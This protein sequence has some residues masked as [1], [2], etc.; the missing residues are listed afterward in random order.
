MKPVVESANPGKKF[1]W[2]FTLLVIFPLIL[3]ASV[4]MITTYVALQDVVKS[5]LL[6]RNTSVVGIAANSADKAINKYLDL[7][8][9]TANVLEKSM[10]RGEAIQLKLLDLEPY[11]TSFEGGVTLL[12]KNGLG[13]ASTQNGLERV[14]RNYAFR[15]Y[16]QDVI[17]YGRPVFSTLIT[18]IPSGQQAVVIA[19][20]VHADAQLEGVLIGVFFLEDHL[21]SRDLEVLQQD[22]QSSAYLIDTA[23]NILYHSDPQKIGQNLHNNPKITNLVNQSSAKSVLYSDAATSSNQVISFAPLHAS[24]WGIVIEEPWEPL[25]APAI[26]YL[27]AVIGFLLLGMIASGAILV[28]NLNRSVAPLVNLMNKAQEISY[29]NDFVPLKLE[30]SSEIRLLINSFNQVVRSLKD[31]QI[32]L[33]RYARQILR[34]QEQERQRISRD[35]HDE[36]VQDLVGL[37]QRLELCRTTLVKD[38]NS[39]RQRLDELQALTARTIDEVRRMSNN[40]RPLILEDLGLI[41]AVRAL[42]K[43]L[44]N[45]IPHMQVNLVISGREKRLPAEIEL[46]TFRVIQESLNNIRKH[47]RSATQVNIQ[48]N[49]LSDELQAI[50]QDN[51]PGFDSLVNQDLIQQ[52]HLGLAGM[53]ERARL[54]GG[55]L[56]IFA[57]PGKFTKVILVIPVQGIFENS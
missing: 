23:G 30:G 52:G 34:S 49:Y 37:S 26:P 2:K 45:D 5:I 20:P 28:I 13:M 51:G 22:P 41:A 44:E 21:W 27:W 39:A 32:Q 47:A 56:T 8:S 55:C 16:F 1:Q 40:L 43:S 19:V 33:Q 50:I 4:A 38:P 35:L 36:T 57:E 10:V 42:G 3:F 14:G 54:F 31:Q 48:I 18:E 24:G 11:L 7:L 46:A 15:P 17:L 25:L 6:Q 29:E 9:G 53:Q 12:S